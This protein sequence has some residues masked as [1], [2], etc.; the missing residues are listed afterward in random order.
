MPDIVYRK[1]DEK[2]SKILTLLLEYGKIIE[3][4]QNKA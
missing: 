2:V 4:K 1:Y 3:E